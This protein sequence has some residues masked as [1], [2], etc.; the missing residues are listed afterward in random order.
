MKEL[1]LDGNPLTFETSYRYTI[2]ASGVKLKMLDTKRVSDEERRMASS[3]LKKELEKKRTE[4]LAKKRSQR[5]QLAIDN[6]VRSGDHSLRFYSTKISF[7][8]TR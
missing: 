7:L 4:E 5:R 3:L 8:L 2:L 6:V 1:T